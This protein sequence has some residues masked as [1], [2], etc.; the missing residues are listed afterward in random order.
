MGFEILSLVFS[1]AAIA[2]VLYLCYKA[3]RFMANKVNGITS[4]NSVKIHERALL[5]QDKGL[6][7]IEVCEKFYLIGFSSTNIDILKELEDFKPKETPIPQNDF[8]N[9]LKSSIGKFNSKKS[10]VNKEN[11]QN[12]GSDEN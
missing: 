5:G 3:S 7:V 1:L 10:G 8:V 6:A 4:S 12:S 2:V 9:A 11:E